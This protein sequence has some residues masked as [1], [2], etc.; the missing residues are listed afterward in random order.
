MSGSNGWSSQGLRKS[1]S[2]VASTHSSNI[3]SISFAHVWQSFASEIDTVP[4][5]EGATCSINIIPKHPMPPS[6][7]FVHLVGNNSNAVFH[8][9]L[10]IK[11]CPSAKAFFSYTAT[12]FF[13]VFFLVCFAFLLILLV[14]FCLRT[15][16]VVYLLFFTVLDC[17]A[18]ENCLNDEWKKSYKE[19]CKTTPH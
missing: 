12:A 16:Y 2:R 18:Q 1:D 8:I 13:A 7:H 3:Y 17:L 5:A 14:V 11:Y 9:H 10:S 6:P 4:F 19:I 15:S